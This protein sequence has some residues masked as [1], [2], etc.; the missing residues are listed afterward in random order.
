MEGHGG[1]KGG[2]LPHA[3]AEGGREEAEGERPVVD[4]VASDEH[5][6]V[7]QPRPQGPSTALWGFS[8]F[9]LD[10][11]DEGNVQCS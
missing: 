11:V 2:G 8:W 7:D 6:A 1:E 10:T 4:V 3:V 9:M 5:A